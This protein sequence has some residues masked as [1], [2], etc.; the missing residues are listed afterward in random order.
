MIDH[1]NCRPSVVLQVACGIMAGEAYPQ[2]KAALLK[3]G[4]TVTEDEALIAS[5]Y[6]IEF[7]SQRA[8]ESNEDVA[9]FCVRAGLPVTRDEALG[10]ARES[11]FS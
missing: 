3:A 6:V 7:L 11:I 5:C 4:S 1:R 8:G 10:L 2:L 9:D